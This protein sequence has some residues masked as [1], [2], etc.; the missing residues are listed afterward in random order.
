MSLVH[1]AAPRLPLGAL[2]V[3]AAAGSLAGC[4]DARRSRA[5]AVEPAMSRVAWPVPVPT[6]HGVRFRLAARG[7]AVGRG[8][9]VGRLRCTARPGARVL[10]HVE[11]F[12]EGLVVPVPPGIG[13]APPLV[14]RGAYVRRGRCSFPVRTTEPTGLLELSRGAP[15][16]LGDLFSV[17]G[18]P[19]SRTRLAAFSTSAGAPVRAYLG[20]RLWRGDP[21]SLPLAAGAVVV[22]EVG[23][24][25][26]PHISYRFPSPQ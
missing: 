24:Y 12:A 11:L 18:Q 4:G 2:A 7:G 21:R 8:H 23:R 1:R 20:G 14:R 5:V 25:V 6:G 13:V 22:L 15:L 26:A 3:L 10:A 17:W 19:L 9:A 16:S